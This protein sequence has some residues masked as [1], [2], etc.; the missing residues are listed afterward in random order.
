[1]TTQATSITTGNR[2]F[3]KIFT[4]SSTDGV[5]S[6]NV[7]TDTISTQSIGILIPNATLT[8]VQPEYE[9]GLMAWRLQNAQ[10]LAVSRFGFAARVGQNSK[11]MIP[12]VRVNPNDILVSYPLPVDATAAKT[13][14]LAWVSTTKGIELFEALAVADNTAT[15]MKTAVNDQTLGDAFFNSTLGAI[16]VQIEDGATLDRVEI[17]DNMG[18]VQMTLQGQVRGATPSSR[19][20]YVNLECGDLAVPIGKGFRLNIVTVS[21]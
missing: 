18:G 13:N 5:W 7:L 3:S 2:Q 20:N 12:P 15:E 16:S 10:T 6:G 4:D 8:F 9:S 19:S 14:T 17:V 11:V 21:E 1:M